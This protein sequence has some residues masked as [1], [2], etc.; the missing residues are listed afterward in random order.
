MEYIWTRRALSELFFFCLYYLLLFQV[1]SDH[2]GG[3][4]SNWITTRPK[5]IRGDYPSVN[6]T[7]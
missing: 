2:N 4:D 1:H 5:P 6:G 3:I 7:V